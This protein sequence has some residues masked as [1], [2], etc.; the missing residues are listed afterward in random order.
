MPIGT[1]RMAHL[2]LSGSQLHVGTSFDEHPS[3]RE[4]LDDP[5]ARPM[6]LFPGPDAADPSL[7]N[8]P[9][10]HL[11]V[12]D[13]T[14]S[15]A[16]KVVRR[17]V[18]LSALP[19]LGLTPDVPGRY[20]IRKEPDE[21]G[22][23]TIEA[24][25]QVLA[26]LAKSPGAFDELLSPFDHMVESQIEH[27]ASG[28]GRMRHGDV[29]KRRPSDALRDA[30][31]DLVVVQAEANE[32]DDA[33]ELVHLVAVRPSTNEWFSCVVAPRHPLAPRTSRHTEL[34]P[35]ALAEGVDIETARVAWKQFAGESTL[36]GWGTFSA[37]LLGA[38]SF[39][40]GPWID[41]RALT[42]LVLARKVGGSE[43]AAKTLDSTF[44][45]AP[46]HG[47]AARLASLHAAVAKGL[48]ERYG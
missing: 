34:S 40:Q 27:A 21:H 15:T 31:N 38:E 3:V 14:W 39:E 33:F 47:R 26:A 25:S 43:G 42:G 18:S 48:V 10:T 30:W 28:K 32:L 8:E 45:G 24:V 44:P 20:R 12:V 36:A 16:A 46:F 41:L 7:L 5:E 22:L 37:E 13:G 17:N 6:L 29:N 23:A 35:E 9:P 19:K 1:A 2:S 4:I 11:F